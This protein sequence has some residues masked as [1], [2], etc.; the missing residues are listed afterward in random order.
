[1]PACRGRRT[2][3]NLQGITSGDRAMSVFQVLSAAL[4][5]LIVAAIA[6]LI[7]ALQIGF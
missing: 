6:I 7:T 1:M 3:R 4:V 5:V 2:R